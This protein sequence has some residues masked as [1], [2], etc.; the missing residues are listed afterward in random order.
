VTRRM[1]SGAVLWGL[2]LWSPWALAQGVVIGDELVVEG[3]S[4]RSSHRTSVDLSLRVSSPLGPRTVPLRKLHEQV[5]VTDVRSSSSSGPTS[6]GVWW[7]VNHQSDG[8][9]DGSRSF[10]LPVVGRGYS[11]DLAGGA[12]V[13]TVAEG[14][15]SD[16]ERS[17]VVQT[18]DLFG[19]LHE[20]RA[21]LPAEMQV[22]SSVPAGAM[23]AGIVR[24]APGDVQ[25]H[26]TLT[27]QEVRGID[28]VQCAMFDLRLQ[29]RSEG[30][31]ESGVRA[32]FTGD[33]VGVV[34][35]EVST[36]WTRRLQV[37]GRIDVTGSG[38]RLG[39][40]FTMVGAGS[41]LSD[42]RLEFQR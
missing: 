30:E 18:A 38:T 4:V 13:V 36:G 11:V 41:F 25:V 16:A 33:L 9:P 10:D 27:L 22:G 1:L 31:L 35:M 17:I 19:L 21:M 2:C 3:L 24:D 8:G 23:F 12:P 34:A 40:T 5:S 26:G 15:L 39:Q 7:S 42:T 29:L 32:V 37:S 14:E 6:M 20:L 28:G